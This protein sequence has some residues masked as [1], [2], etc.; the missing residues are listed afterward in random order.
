MFPRFS[1]WLFYFH[2]LTL[3]YS[4]GNET[5]IIYVVCL[6]FLCFFSIFIDFPHNGLFAI[7]HLIELNVKLPSKMVSFIDERSFET[8]VPKTSIE[9]LLILVES[10]VGLHVCD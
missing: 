4:F 10:L 3:C 7:D 9:H 5:V 1:L 2:L 8:C 6:C